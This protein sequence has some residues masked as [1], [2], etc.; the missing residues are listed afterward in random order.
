VIAID[1]GTNAIVRRS[2]GSGPD[3]MVWSAPNLWVNNAGGT[4]LSIVP[5]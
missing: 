4:S 5:V 2:V 1:P 3:R